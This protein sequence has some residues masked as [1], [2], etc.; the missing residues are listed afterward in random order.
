MGLFTYVSHSI[1][2]IGSWVYEFLFSDVSILFKK[3]RVMLEFWNGH[4]DTSSIHSSGIA[5][6][7]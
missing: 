2:E 3:K 6:K 1:I 7:Y 5:A 4:D